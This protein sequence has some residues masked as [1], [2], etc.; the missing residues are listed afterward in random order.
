MPYSILGSTKIL[1]YFGNRTIFVY[2][3]WHPLCLWICYGA[4][5][6]H[7]TVSPRRKGT[8]FFLHIQ[9]RN[10]Q[11]DLNP[12]LW[13]YYYGK[14]IAEL[15]KNTNN[16]KRQTVH[17][18]CNLTKLHFNPLRANPTKWSNTLKQFVG[19]LPTNCLSVFEHF[20]K[21]GLKGL[22]SL[23]ICFWFQI[24]SEQSFP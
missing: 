4:R 20:L 22:K 10:H 11:N 7:F 3:S 23:Y 15:E 2:F 13:L 18:A 8:L 14:V 5:S 17:G 19:N 24:M 6:A 21:L 1:I 16:K 12:C 9:L